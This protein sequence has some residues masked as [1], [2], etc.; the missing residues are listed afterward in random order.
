[1]I[2]L[3]FHSTH[4]AIGAKKLLQEKG[5]VTVLPTPTS[6]TS[7]CG[8]S[9]LADEDTVKFLMDE[10]AQFSPV[11]YKEISGVYYKV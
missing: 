4:Q 2:L 5:S 3:T 9:L 7:E 6:I 8:M 10:L 1:M 11:L